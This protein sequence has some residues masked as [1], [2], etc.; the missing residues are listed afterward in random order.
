MWSPP[1]FGSPATV[2]KERAPESSFLP[3]AKSRAAALDPSCAAKQAVIPDEE[4]TPINTLPPA[5]PPAG[6]PPVAASPAATTADRT[7]FREAADALDRER[8]AL[9]Q[10]VAE[11]LT[12]VLER[13]AP[14]LAGLDLAGQADALA[15][16]ITGPGW[17]LEC[18]AEVA[19]ALP[20]LALPIRTVSGETVALRR[21]PA[22]RQFDPAIAAE[23][24]VAEIGGTLALI[25][26]NTDATARDGNPYPVG[27]SRPSK[28]KA[29]A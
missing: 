17:I 2:A 14:R 16:S 28:G 3:G 10:N 9:E 19:E 24:I 21:D 15:R 22:A 23:R 6:E 4:A 7:R 25:Q 12:A 5:P 13:L 1:A 18:P 11:L 8:S 20:P 29:A 27:V 26:T